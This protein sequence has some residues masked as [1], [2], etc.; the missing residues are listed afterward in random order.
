MFDALRPF[1]PLVF[2]ALPICI[3]RPP[4][5][6]DDEEAGAWSD[7][8]PAAGEVAPLDDGIEEFSPMPG[9]D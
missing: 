3:P 8:E 7:D 4:P 6:W 9:Y 2:F 5:R 1:F